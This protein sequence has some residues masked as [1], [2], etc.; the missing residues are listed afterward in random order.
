MDDVTVSRREEQP[1]AVI[2]STCSMS[3]LGQRLGEILPMVYTAIL[4][5]G[6]TPTQPP[7]LRYLSM[8]MENATLDFA[9]GIPVDAPI[10]DAA[11]VYAAV[12]PGGEVAALWHVGPYQELGS[13]HERLDAWIAA[14]GRQQ[15]DGR[16]EVYWT[17]PGEEPDPAKWRTEVIQVLI[18]QV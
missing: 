7:F 10:A 3:E 12:L 4:E 14:H 8:D 5:Q 16:W 9:A 6:R 2:R 15:G 1:V 17:D 11:P 13:A 18:P